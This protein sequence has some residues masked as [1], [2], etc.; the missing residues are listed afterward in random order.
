MEEQPKS[1]HIEN[2]TDNESDEKSSPSSIPRHDDPEMFAEQASSNREDYDRKSLRSDTME[3][4]SESSNIENSTESDEKSSPASIPKH[5]DPEM[6]AEQASSNREDYDR[7]S[8]QSDTMEEQPQSSNIENS[9]DNESDDKS[10]PSSIPR[11]DDP[12]MSAE[13]ASSNREDYDRK[14]LRSDTM[15]EQSESSNI[16]NSTESDE[17]SSP[18]SIPKH[19]DPEISAEQALSNR[20]NYDRKSLQS[21]TMEEQ[22]ESSNIENSTESDDKSSPPSIPRHND[23]EMSAEQASSNREGYDRKS[24]QS[25]T[26]EEQ[27]ES[28]NIEN[29]T[30][31][32]DK[33]SPPSIPRHNDPEMSAEQASSNRE[34]YDSNKL[35]QSEVEKQ[36][37]S[38]NI[39]NFT[40][41]DDK[42][43]PPS[44]PKHDVPEMSAEQASSNRKN[45]DSKS[46]ES[47]IME[48]QHESSDIENYPKSNEKSPSPSISKHDA[49][50]T[51]VEQGSPS[52]TDNVRGQVLVDNDAGT[53][54]TKCNYS[55][56]TKTLN[57]PESST[58]EP[59]TTES[60][61]MKSSG[62]ESNAT[63]IAQPSTSKS[64][65][66][67]KSQSS[68]ESTQKNDSD[69]K[70]KENQDKCQII[71]TKAEESMDLTADIH[72]N[73]S[74]SPAS[75]PTDDQAEAMNDEVF[76]KF[77]EKFTS[78]SVSKD[79]SLQ[80]KYLNVISKLAC[81]ILIFLFLILP[82]LV[83]MVINKVAS[84][85]MI[86]YDKAEKNK[87]PEYIQD[88]DI[89]IRRKKSFT[90]LKC[91]IILLILILS[92]FLFLFLFYFHFRSVYLDKDDMHFDT[93]ATTVVELEKRV[94]DH[95]ATIRVLTEYLVKDIFIEANIIMK[96]IPFKPL[97]EE[98]LEKHIKNTA[99]NIGQT[100]SQDQIDY[101]K[102][103]LIEDDTDCQRKYDC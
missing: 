63:E 27:P 58:T 13:Q 48:K 12:E 67:L 40:E 50:K 101:H 81:R 94:L 87:K 65:L 93:F 85:Y 44:I 64:T 16:E 46:S 79:K 54:V 86:T 10:S 20:E 55:S 22:P 41:S 103:R 100:F 28:S 33:S 95:D 36:S 24:L 53:N 42:S 59:S 52:R 76:V 31:S 84:K 21:D 29:S 88:T 83:M 96:I 91:F 25:D 5:D 30:E 72:D 3:E 43:S 39:E 69:N 8:L 23:P 71:N 34:G 78:T 68:Q 11:H 57:L 99:K 90:C 98:T 75:E 62:T 14:S 19:D 51:S 77:L 61:P 92:L 15:E 82:Q 89:K 45:Y 6:S 102:R 38:S 60:S 17:K 4:Q 37:E 18:P 97:S 70:P 35:L 66:E 73:T 1:S 49:L 74:D 47:D 32:D 26:M 7:K 80:W 9:T 56:E 2:S